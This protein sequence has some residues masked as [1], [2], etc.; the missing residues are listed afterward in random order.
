VIV[1]VNEYT[2]SYAESIAMF[3]QTLPQSIIVGSQTAGA[4]GNTVRVPLPG[5]IRASFSNIIIEYPDGNQ[6]QK[7]GI[8]INLPVELS[9]ED[10]ISK[11]DPYIDL[12][13][14]IVNNHS[15]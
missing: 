5:S 1:L 4:N 8:R 2:Q 3:F 15:L 10:I 9:I 7:N 13:R 12:A 11:R 14:K 6:F